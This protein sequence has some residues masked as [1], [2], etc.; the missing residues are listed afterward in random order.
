MTPAA[1][2]ALERFAASIDGFRARATGQGAGELVEQVVADVGILVALAEEGPE[3]E[4]R[5][6]NVREL[7]AGAYQFD[8]RLPGLRELEDLPTD[9]HRWTCS[10][11]RSPLSRTWTATI[12]RPTPSHS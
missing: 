6:D 1:G 7:I 4:D 2:A 5:I 11:R 10:S 9:V 3:A 12:R 8:D